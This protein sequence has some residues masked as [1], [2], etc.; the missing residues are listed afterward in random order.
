MFSWFSQELNVAILVPFCDLFLFLILITNVYLIISCLVSLN[1]VYAVRM[2]CD[3]FFPWII[4]ISSGVL[5]QDGRLQVWPH[6]SG[7]IFLRSLEIKLEL[8]NKISRLLFTKL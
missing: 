2:R 6:L 7:L 1:L 5:M 3:F 8:S 4:L